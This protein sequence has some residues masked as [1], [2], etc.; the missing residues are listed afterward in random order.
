MPNYLQKIIDLLIAVVL[1]FLIPAL[2]FNLKKD[3]VIQ[4]NADRMTTE[5]VETVAADGYI[6][7]E[8]YEKYLERLAGTGKLYDIELIHEQTAFEP[9][10]KLRSSA[11]VIEEDEGLWTGTNEYF[12]PEVV[13]EIPAVSDPISTGSLNMETNESV[14]AKAK[15]TPADPNHVHTGECYTG[16]RHEG[17]PTFIH[18]HQHTPAC[19][20]FRD[21]LFA[22]VTCRDCGVTSHKLVASWYWEEESNSVKVGMMFSVNSECWDCGSFNTSTVTKEGYEYSCGYNVDLDQDGFYDDSVGTTRAYQYTSNVP[23][24][25]QGKMTVVKE[26]YKYH[27][28][29]LLTYYPQGLTYRYI[30][31]NDTNGPDN[32]ILQIR[33]AGSLRNFCYL[34]RDFS[35][36]L[37]DVDYDQLYVDVNYHTEILPDGTERFVFVSARKTYGASRIDFTLPNL[38]T[39][40][41]C[42]LYS[43]YGLID[44][45]SPYINLKDVNDVPWALD[46]TCSGGIALCDETEGWQVIC[47]LEESNNI[48]CTQLVKN[49]VPTHPTQTVYTGDPLITTAVAT[50]ADGSTKTVVCTS[51][52]STAGIVKN[53]TTMLTYTYRIGTISYLK[54][55]SITVTVIPRNKTCV[56]GHT[57]NLNADGSDPAC[58]YCRNWLRSLAV[59]VPSIGSLTMYR[60]PSGSLK[61]EGVG[62]IAVYLDGHTEYVFSDYIDNLDPDYV[63]TQTVTIGYKGLTTSLTVTVVRNRTKCNVCGLYYDLHMDDSDPGCPYCKAKVPVFTGHVKQYTSASYRD[64]ITKELFDGSGIYYFRRGDVFTVEAKSRKSALEVSLIG[65]LFHLSVNVRSGDTIKNEEVHY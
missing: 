5:F 22:D 60:N 40:Q 55:C 9:E 17:D 21:L 46:I 41:F 14:M 58:P 24:D 50:F 34:P 45:I 28:H 64:E 53:Q 13:T 42:N 47:G 29:G 63:G 27:Q 2:Y 65:R 33:N 18:T 16:H 52:F 7:R 59:L 32:P 39:T 54:S 44:F 43:T 62:L 1:M 37:V 23:Q 6:T 56:N 36:R 8:M 3:A 61:T 26:C 51:S 10:Y 48:A 38:T 31:H 25:I 11:E 35:L 15:D 57:Y 4:I 12:A 49:L 30:S 19:I 20:R